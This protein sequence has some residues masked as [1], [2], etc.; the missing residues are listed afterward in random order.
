[1]GTLLAFTTVAIS[2]LVVRYAP[3]YE[4]PMEV[5]LAGSSESPTSFS[6]HLENDEQNS[7]DLFGNGMRIIFR[8][9]LSSSYGRNY[10]YLF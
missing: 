4:M 5:A 9:L 10:V 8:E 7:E 3:P 6:G 2:V 1:M